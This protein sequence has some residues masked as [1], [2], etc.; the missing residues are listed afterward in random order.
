MIHLPSPDVP[1]VAPPTAGASGRKSEAQRRDCPSG[2]AVSQCVCFGG[3]QGQ[4]DRTARILHLGQRP[5]PCFCEERIQTCLSDS[6]IQIAHFSLS[7]HPE[8]KL[9]LRFLASSPAP[10][11][12]ISIVKN[13]FYF[14]IYF[15]LCP[16]AYLMLPF[17]PTLLIYSLQT[18]RSLLPCVT[19]RP[20]SVSPSVNVSNGC[21]CPCGLHFFTSQL[22]L[23]LQ[24]NEL[25]CPCDPL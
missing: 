10:S 4:R 15:S 13:L 18:H 6:F 8:G 17:P 2:C 14:H 20:F 9:Q 5:Q 24:S 16:F 21:I 19:R 23:T 22:C 12:D 3:Q 7:C 25:S 1:K 11:P